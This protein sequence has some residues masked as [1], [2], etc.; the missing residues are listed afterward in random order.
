MK[1]RLLDA[2]VA[3]A[4]LGVASPASADIIDVTFSG[5]VKI[6]FNLLNATFFTLTGQSVPYSSLQ[7]DAY[8]TTFVINTGFGS[9]QTSPTGTKY[10]DDILRPSITFDGFGTYR[11]IYGSSTIFIG[12]DGSVQ[13]NVSG[14]DTVFDLTSR[15]GFFQ[16]GPCPGS[17]CGFLSAETE[18]VTDPSVPVPG[19][20]VGAGLPGLVLA[21]GGLL[22]WRRRRGSQAAW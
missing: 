8:T 19:P 5:A 14:G 6:P 11:P 4:L 18:T 10:V 12:N 16:T 21:G 13:V 15:G 22:A 17:P 3:L 2:A 1:A 9:S 20:A 7:A